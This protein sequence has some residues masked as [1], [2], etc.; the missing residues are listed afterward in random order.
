MT[1]RPA[2]SSRTSL[3]LDWIL[4]ALSVWLIGGFYVDIWAHAHGEVDDTFFTP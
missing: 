2:P 1:E 3:R 4:A